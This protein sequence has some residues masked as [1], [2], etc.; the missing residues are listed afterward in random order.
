M[1]LLFLV[2]LVLA[3]VGT[4]IVSGVFFAFSGFVMQGLDRL[5]PA[6]AARAMREIN[7]TAPRPPL[8]LALFG[9]GLVLVAIVV[10]VFAF[11]GRIAGNGWWMT[12]AAIIYVVGAIGVTA[13]ANVPRNNRLAAV[14]ETDDAALG[15]AWREFRPGWVA[16]NHVRWLTSAA[17]CVCLV[18]AL[19]LR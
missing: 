5:P 11:T 16:W 3:I 12:A 6:D 15:A 7:V 1:D 19:L 4:G 8:M 17:A 14:S 2:L 18:V 13:G 10:L 9:T